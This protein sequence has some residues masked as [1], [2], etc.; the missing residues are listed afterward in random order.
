MLMFRNCG[1]SSAP[2]PVDRE[3]FT[4]PNVRSGSVRT[5]TGTSTASGSR[6]NRNIGC[7]PNRGMTGMASSAAIDP[8]I[9]T[10]DIIIVA[11]GPRH[12]GRISSAAS[13]LAVGTRPPRPMPA[14]SRS[15]P[16]TTGPVAN[17]HSAVNTDSTTAHP[18]TARLRPIASESRPASTAPI[19]IPT[20]ARLPRVP[21]VA[22]PIPHS[23]CRLEITL[24]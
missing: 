10:P 1:P 2:K 6:A 13:A 8:P 21:A 12:F 24:P 17:A 3:W 5:A 15:T 20:N 14:I 16:N 23:R 18:I 4:S 9:G 7:H 11:T 22:G 19:I